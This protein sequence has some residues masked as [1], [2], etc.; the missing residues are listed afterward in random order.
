M[1]FRKKRKQ[2]KKK[3]NHTGIMDSALFKNL[4]RIKIEYF[5]L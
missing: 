1:G 2:E 4:C 5:F 3:P